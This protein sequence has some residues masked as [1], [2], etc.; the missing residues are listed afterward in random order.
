MRSTPHTSVPRWLT[1]SQ[2][3]SIRRL[4]LVSAPVPP[5][6]AAAAPV[7]IHFP[8]PVQPILSVNVPVS[9]VDAELS[10]ARRVG[11]AFSR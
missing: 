6:A 8:R 5:A 4:L 7:Q 1:Y 3:E 9:A 11:Y 2:Q 10:Q